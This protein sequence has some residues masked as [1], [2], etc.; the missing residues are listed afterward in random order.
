VAIFRGRIKHTELT[1]PQ[2]IRKYPSLFSDPP[3]TE[4][5]CR[6][7]YITIQPAHARDLRICMWPVYLSRIFQGP[8]SRLPRLF[9]PCSVYWGKSAHRF[10][11]PSLL[12]GFKLIGC[13]KKRVWESGAS[14]QRI[15]IIFITHSRREP[16][17]V[18]SGLGTKLFEVS[19]RLVFISN[20]FQ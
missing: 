15:A 6:R 1:Y 13:A 4:N 8:I 5:E 9:K 19:R 11:R 2:H 14:T 7:N 17:I 16:D 20:Y 18:V 10:A 3:H 12:Q